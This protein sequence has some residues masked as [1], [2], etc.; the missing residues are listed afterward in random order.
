MYDQLYIFVIYLHQDHLIPKKNTG[1]SSNWHP[2]NGPF[3]VMK[4]FCR[5]Q[6]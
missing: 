2:Q 6:R 3:E 4:P 1:Q 5:Y